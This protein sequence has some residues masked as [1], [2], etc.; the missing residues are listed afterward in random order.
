LLFK[1]GKEVEKNIKGWNHCPMA[2][3]EEPVQ[4]MA[5]LSFNK[6]ITPNDDDLGA[7]PS[8]AEVEKMTK[9]NPKLNSSWAIWGQFVQ[10]RDSKAAYSDATRQLATFSSVKEFWAC[11]L[12]LPQPSELL[13]GKKIMKETDEDS[14]IIESIMIF[15]KGV[16][17]E[18]EDE[19]NT[20]GGHFTL[21]LKP[22]LGGGIIDE[23]WNN[24]VLGTLS[25]SIENSDMIT[26]IRLVDKLS[27]NSKP[28]LRVEVWF[29]DI[30]ADDKIYKLRGSMEDCLRQ[31]L[32]GTYKK[33]V[34][35]STE[36]KSH[37][38]TRK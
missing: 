38:P 3:T 22:Q 24:V 29:N 25:C 16:R 12:H 19:A 14:Q 36:M 6:S 32:D 4:P 34:W 21:Q 8:E 7:A 5:F 28:M 17:P 20:N 1:T 31:R 26:G 27:S 13:S 15:R 35:G 33:L 10:A 9:Q 18:W 30:S 23:L 37:V 2:S 11:W